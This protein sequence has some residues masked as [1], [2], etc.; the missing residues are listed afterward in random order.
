MV[1][2]DIMTNDLF[3]GKLFLSF[4][5]QLIVVIHETREGL[6]LYDCECWSYL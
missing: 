3:W 6:G 4:Q 2:N 5:F 1:W